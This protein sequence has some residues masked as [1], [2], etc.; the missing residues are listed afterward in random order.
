MRPTCPTHHSPRDPYAC[1]FQWEP[2]TYLVVQD[3]SDHNDVLMYA[4][5][6]APS[7]SSERALPHDHDQPPNDATQRKT[8]AASAADLNGAI[9]PFAFPTSS[10]V[11]TK[12][13]R[14]KFLFANQN[15]R[16]IRAWKDRSCPYPDLRRELVLFKSLEVVALL[17]LRLECVE[18]VSSRL[19]SAFTTLAF[20]NRF[21]VCFRA[22][23]SH[24]P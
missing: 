15:G 9:I 8:L 23:I 5:S 1:G 4:D 13:Q 24:H 19:F 11:Q 10:A 22:A 21:S 20:M 2:R 3:L 16:P 14:H 12:S 6:P 18:L 17:M 7:N